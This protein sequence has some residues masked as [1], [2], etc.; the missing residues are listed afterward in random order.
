[1]GW[2]QLVGSLKMWVSFAKEPYKKDLYSAKEIYIFKE[3][4]N[5]RH[6]ISTHNVFHSLA[7][8]LSR[9]RALFLSRSKKLERHD[10]DSQN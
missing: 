3:P 8:W 9:L 1:M 4:T 10:D 2:P 5:R 7:L 6:P